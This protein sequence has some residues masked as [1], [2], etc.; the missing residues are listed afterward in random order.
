MSSMQ[1]DFQALGREYRHQG[2]GPGGVCSPAAC[3]PG[4]LPGTSRLGPNA[5]T[6]V[7]SCHGGSFRFGH[8]KSSGVEHKTF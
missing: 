2:F 4:M 8:E 7:H 3:S 1:P 6:V 5:E